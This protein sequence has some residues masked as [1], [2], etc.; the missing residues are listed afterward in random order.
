MVVAC[1]FANR[2][3]FPVMFKIWCQVVC[4]SKEVVYSVF[5]HTMGHKEWAV[6]AHASEWHL[7]DGQCFLSLSYQL[8][9]ILVCWHVPQSSHFSSASLMLAFVNW[10]V[11]GRCWISPIFKCACSCMT[12]FYSFWKTSAIYLMFHLGNMFCLWPYSVASWINYEYLSTRCSTKDR[13]FLLWLSYWLRWML[14]CSCG[15]SF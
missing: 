10:F 3:F 9:S 6:N 15:T 2:I 1:S 14:T 12:Q 7:Q 8:R 5:G 13:H 4:H 11:N